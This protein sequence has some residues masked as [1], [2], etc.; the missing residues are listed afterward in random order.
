M[1]VRVRWKDRKIRVERQKDKGRKIE[2]DGQKDRKSQVERQIEMGRKIE[3]VRWKDRKRWE[4]R[5]KEMGGKIE[6][7]RQKDDLSD[8]LEIESGECW[9]RW[10]DSTYNGER[11]KER[12]IDA[13]EG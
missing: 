7:V 9:P 8:N 11:Q 6:R 13:R 10:V 4:E 1:I 3:R 2:R 5:Q 12:L